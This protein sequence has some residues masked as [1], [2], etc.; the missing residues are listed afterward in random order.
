MTHK[1]LK[2]KLPT[3]F[4]AQLATFIVEMDFWA[5]REKIVTEENK[6]PLGPRPLWGDFAGKR[7]PAAEFSVE[8]AKWE[9]E[10]LKRHAPVKKPIASPDV[11]AAVQIVDGKH[12]A[13]FEVVNDDPTPEQV[14]RT[15][16]DALIQRIHQ[17]EEVAKRRVALPLGKLRLAA[18]REHDYLAIAEEDRTPDQIAH[19]EAQVAIQTKLAAIYR[20]GAEATS[21][22][23]DL[24]ADN[25]DSFVLPTF[26]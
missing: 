13:D 3:D 21:E 1:I 8:M 2:S 17:D 20:T 23:E 6:K 19:I 15:K 24:T 7:D 10:R 26:D 9:A 16:K 14:L 18:L 5:E 11:V 22:I 25:I 12:V 4:D